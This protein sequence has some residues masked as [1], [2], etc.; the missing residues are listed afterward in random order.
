[1]TVRAGM[2]ASLKTFVM[3]SAWATL[4]QKPRARIPPTLAI[5]SRT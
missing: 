3:Y 2:P 1:M 4:T 5:L